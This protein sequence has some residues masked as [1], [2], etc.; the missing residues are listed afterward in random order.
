MG[1]VRA[2]RSPVQPVA[3][4][5]E[6]VGRSVETVPGFRQLERFLDEVA[7]AAAFGIALIYGRSGGGSPSP[8]S[9]S[10]SRASNSGEDLGIKRAGTKRGP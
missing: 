9:G 3:R 4:S 7:D 8:L 5:L 6:N 10:S 2:V 1:K